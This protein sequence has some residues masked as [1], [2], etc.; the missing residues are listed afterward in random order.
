MAWNLF[1]KFPFARTNQPLCIIEDKYPVF[2]QLQ[3]YYV[4]VRDKIWIFR[5]GYVH[6]RFPC[7]SR[8]LLKQWQGA[9]Y[10]TFIWDW[11]RLPISHLCLQ[12]FQLCFHLRGRTHLPHR[13]NGT[14]TYH[15]VYEISDTTLACSY[16][17][18]TWVQVQINC[19]PC[20]H[21]GRIAQ[22]RPR[23]CKI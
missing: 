12:V 21:F 16:C 19:R 20:T 7:T 22:E 17:P 3:Y 8:C 5:V 1:W 6:I 11:G 2:L 23:R 14:L 9:T 10:N 15:T 4:Q 18:L 13:T